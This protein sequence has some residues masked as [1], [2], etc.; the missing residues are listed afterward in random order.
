MNF[1][2]PLILV[3]IPL[4][5]LAA[6]L[7]ATRQRGGAFSRWGLLTAALRTLAIS[8]TIA[9]L[10]APYTSSSKPADS[11]SAL[12][13]IS[14]SITTQQGDAMLDKARS[15]AKELDVPLRVRAFAKRSATSDA[16]LA[17]S[18]SYSELRSM[19]RALD[20]GASNIEAAIDSAGS[21]RSPLLLL[22]DGYETAGS[23]RERLA[24]LS[25]RPIYPLTALGEDSQSSLSISQLHAPLT[26]LALRSV[27]VRVTITNSAPPSTKAKA[28]AATLE[29]R[30]GDSVILSRSVAVP[31]QEDLS[32]VAQSDPS[33]EGLQPIHAKLTWNDDDGAHVVSKTIWLS[34]EKRNKVLLLSGSADD[35]RYLSRILSDQSYQLRSFIA[36]GPDSG[37]GPLEDYRVVVLNNVH[38]SRL[39][40]S[41]ERSVARY[42]ENGG[43]LVV[44]GGTTSYGLGGYIGSSLEP[45][46]PVRLVPPHQ[47]KKRLTIA[48]QLVIDK[49]RSMATDNRLEFAK[50]SAEEVV[51]TLLDDDYLGVI[52]FDEVPFIALPLSPLRSVR[53]VALSRI[54][55]LFP[56]SRTN[57]FPALDEARRGLASINAGRK[58]IIVLTDGKLPDPGP[59]YL[60]LVKQARFVGITLSTIMV[61]AEADDGFLQQ[62]AVQGGGAFYQTAD[63]RNLPRVFLSDVKVASGERTLKED[64]GLTVRPGPDPIVSTTLTSF[65]TPRGFVETQE[66]EQASTEL[67]V[68]NAEGSYPLLSSWN[69]KQGRV[70]A[71]TSDANGRWSADWMRWDRIQEFWAD[72]IESAQ[73]RQERRSSS[74]MQF[75]LRSWTEGGDVVIDLSIFDEHSSRNVKAEVTTPQGER[76][77]VS[78]TQVSTGHFQ[79]RVAN[80]TAGTYRADIRVGNEV[81]PPVAWE[82]AA[83]LFGERTHRNPNIALL[84]E[85]SAATAGA[86]DPTAQSLS[87]NMRQESS[88]TLFSKQLIVAALLLVLLELAMRVFL[89][90]SRP[91]AR[92]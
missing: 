3:L 25:A 60:D 23:I 29:V 82:L 5:V 87:S 83:E 53:D 26:A 90:R 52:G 45:L 56:T 76:V 73:K 13:D 55:R 42:V 67:L 37:V 47:E 57:L 66:R 19:W 86:I 78:F 79:A 46:L 35:D 41:I 44:V 12:L 27:D 74:R 68:R 77:Q 65:P 24:G 70:I 81:L 48:V 80:A 33:I 69:F 92:Y 75:D 89:Y 9:A 43:G 63:P 16:P 71:F 72:I 39:S 64:S 31:R 11:L 32:L 20:S 61:G 49:S 36:P 1:S 59:Y 10:A 88:R 14:A 54:S 58:H 28:T 4:V 18:A 91:G 2:F 7:I 21:S 38:L 50:A 22:S 30:H 84:S 85:I 34:G 17:S 51:R 62:L 40:P 15:L 6:L 8:L